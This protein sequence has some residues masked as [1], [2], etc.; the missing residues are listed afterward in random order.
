MGQALGLVKYLYPGT[1]QSI[2]VQYRTVCR[3][4]RDGWRARRDRPNAF[5]NESQSPGPHQTLSRVLSPPGLIAAQ[6][7]GTLIQLVT[8]G[9]KAGCA[10]R[11]QSCSV[12]LHYPRRAHYTGQGRLHIASVP[13]FCSP[14]A[15]PAA[16]VP[17]PTE[18][19]RSYAIIGSMSP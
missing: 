3:V 10:G 2:S 11:P 16:T 15:I 13:N 4:A 19:K 5:P 14:P 8:P 9:V 7:I 17:L 12:A 1:V 18:S 6:M